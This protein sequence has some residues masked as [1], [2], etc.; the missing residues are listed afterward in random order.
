MTDRQSCKI[1]RAAMFVVAILW[2]ETPPLSAQTS[3][4]CPT[5]S[6]NPEIVY[7]QRLVGCSLN[8]PLDR[9]IFLFQGAPEELVRFTLRKQGGQGSPCLEIYDPSKT[10][11][12]GQTCGSLDFNLTLSQNGRYEVVVRE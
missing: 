3:V 5:Q 2:A 4:V 6:T 8:R 1:L 7:G 12:G 9:N 11:L 10:L